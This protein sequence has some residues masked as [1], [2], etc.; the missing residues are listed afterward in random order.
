MASAEG[1]QAGSHHEAVSQKQVW[2]RRLPLFVYRGH[3]RRLIQS[4][5]QMSCQ[6]GWLSDLPLLT[7]NQDDVRSNP[8]IKGEE[9]Q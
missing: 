2:L 1:C 4:R 8:C 5:F 9:F 6:Q 7:H 3:H